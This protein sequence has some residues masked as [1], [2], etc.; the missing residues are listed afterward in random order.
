MKGW[1][2][3]LTW[4][5]VLN[6]CHSWS[7]WWPHSDGDI[8]G[9]R[10]LFVAGSQSPSH[11][12]G[13]LHWVAR[14]DWALKSL[15]LGRLQLTYLSFPK[16]LKGSG[17]HSLCIHALEKNKKTKNPHSNNSCL[18]PHVTPL[19]PTVGLCQYNVPLSHLVTWKL[20]VLGIYDNHFGWN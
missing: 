9:Q 16:N 5:K 6:Q 1:E 18:G 8:W 3:L 14:M 15:A 4:W 17:Q 19:S 7:L 13:Q 20:F 2:A 12:V 10:V 11:K